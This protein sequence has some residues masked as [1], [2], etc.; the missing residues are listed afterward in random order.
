MIFYGNI[1]ILL[2]HLWPTAL[3]LKCSSFFSTF[4]YILHA[5]KVET[6]KSCLVCCLSSSSLCFFENGEVKRTHVLHSFPINENIL[7]IWVSDI[8]IPPYSLCFPWCFRTT[9][10]YIL[11]AVQRQTYPWWQKYR[12][13]CTSSQR[14]YRDIAHVLQ[15][16]TADG[17]VQ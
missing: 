15:Q 1:K 6:S 9:D 2:W 14:K 16:E 13:K 12:F 17:Y 10:R 7:F 11:F 3:K 5:K 4:C 8:L